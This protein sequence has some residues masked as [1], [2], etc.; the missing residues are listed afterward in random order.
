MIDNNKVA[1]VIPTEILEAAKGKD[2][3]VR[4]DM[5]GYSW[6]INGKDIDS[7]SKEE[8]NLEVTVDVDVASDKVLEELTKGNKDSMQIALT[9]DGEFG[10]DATLTLN[11]GEDKKNQY[12]NLYWYKD[13]GEVELIEAAKVDEEGKVKLNFKHAS[14]YILVYDNVDR[15][16]VKPE[17][18]KNEPPA[19][20]TPT[21][22]PEAKPET[23]P[24]TT[25][26]TGD[27]DMTLYVMMLACG[28]GMLGILKK[29]KFSR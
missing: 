25:P 18:P 3:D 23:K 16:A 27:A 9:H 24:A 10:F 1:T 14:K 6:T 17:T 26:K 4:F 20:T 2:V 15:T 22:T 13:N 12:V 8:I 7:I 29:K 5:N 21:T 19:V 28:F 11:V